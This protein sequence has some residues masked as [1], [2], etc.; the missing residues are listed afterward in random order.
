M[1]QSRHL[2]HGAVAAIGSAFLFAS[3]GACIKLLSATVP[4]ET[5]VFFRNAVALLALIPWLVHAGLGAL[6]TRRLPMH[7]WRTAFG[8]TAMYC[9]FSVLAHMPLAEAVLLNFSAPLFTPVIAR[10]WLDEPVPL[11]LYGAVGLGFLGIALILKPGLELFQPMGLIGLMSGLFAAIAVTGV[12]RMS[13]TEPIP[14]IVFYFS[15]FSTAVSAVPLSWHW[16]RPSPW[17]LALLVLMGLLA[18]GG[19][20]LM[21]R[22]YA[23]APAARVGPL[24]YS[25]VVFAAAYGLMLWKEAPD[26]WSIG[27]AVLVAIAGMLA[28]RPYQVSPLAEECVTVTEPRES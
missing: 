19:Q 6:A 23:L 12:R 13:F 5:V 18:T 10:L 14:R 17:E 16:H 20:L 27:G 15:V 25:S 1:M 28:A 22:A 9:F 7:L 3:M 21:T 8:L 11:Q 24:T 2:T 4:T 26:A